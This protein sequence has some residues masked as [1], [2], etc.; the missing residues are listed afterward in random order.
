MEAT[1][2]GVIIFGLT[3]RTHGEAGHRGQRAVI[4]D[5]AGDRK[6]R[7]T[8]GAVDKGVAIAA[9]GW[10]EEF[11][12]AVSTDGLVRRDQGP[13]RGID[14]AMRNYKIMSSL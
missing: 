3:G 7:A 11:T 1:V 4:G 12:Q 9:I 2:V 8:V 5:V 6:T 10:V 13:L 14:L